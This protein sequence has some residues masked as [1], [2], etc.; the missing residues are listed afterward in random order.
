MSPQE[1]R[2]AITLI[3]IINLNI[4]LNLFNTSYLMSRQE[5]WTAIKNLFIGRFDVIGSD[6]YSITTKHLFSQQSERYSITIKI[7]FPTNFQNLLLC[8]HWILNSSY[9]LRKRIMFI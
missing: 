4:L 6:G 5:R 7:L 9:F 1:G 2:T 3:G 8:L